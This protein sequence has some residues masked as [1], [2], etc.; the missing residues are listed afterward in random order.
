MK[1]VKIS[2]Y[3]SI[4]VTIPIF[5]LVGMLYLGQTSLT[6]VGSYMEKL[7]RNPYATSS[8][9]KDIRSGVFEL[10]CLNLEENQSLKNSRKIE[11]IN[12]NVEKSIEI[13]KISYLGDHEH[14]SAL[15]SKYKLWINSL[16]ERR[17]SSVQPERSNPLYN[18]LLEAVDSINMYADTKGKEFYSKASLY[19][20]RK[21]DVFLYTVISSIIVLVLASIFVSRRLNHIISGIMLKLKKGGVVVLNESNEIAKSSKALSDETNEAASALQES[22]SSMEELSAMVKNN[23][24]QAHKSKN[25]S[26]EMEK[27]A[28]VVCDKTSELIDSMGKIAESNQD[29]ASLVLAIEEIAEKTKIIDDI[30]FQTKILSFNAS[31][32]AER[33][34]EFGRGFSVVAQEVS[35]LAKTSGRA[36]TEIS[37]IVKSSVKNAQVIY[38]N[39]KMRVEKGSSLVDDTA[40]FIK[41]IEEDSANIRLNIEQIL[42]ASQDQAAGISQMNE[43]IGQLDQSTQLNASMATLSST[44]ALELNQQAINLQAMVGEL[45]ILVNGHRK[46]QDTDDQRSFAQ[47]GG[48]VLILQDGHSKLKGVNG[49]KDKEFRKVANGA[50]SWEKI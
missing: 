6:G 27:S 34:G 37:E 13:L 10:Q 26:E 9:I 17:P 29:I 49:T 3:L 19:T 1:K 16:F 45:E 30:V 15:E 35:N 8:S 41:K 22:A 25:L 18:N 12:K 39:N 21:I 46:S 24:N 38:E 23:V 33:A 7:Y 44:A 2:H 36:S 11:E 48:K 47:E 50:N 32:E 40:S 5:I 42:S 43:A 20:K 31:V 14:I 28:K 4:L